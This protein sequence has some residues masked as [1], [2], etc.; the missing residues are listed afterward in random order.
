M[1]SQELREA[2]TNSSFLEFARTLR[3]APPL[4]PKKYFEA[5]ET[6]LHPYS[7][8]VDALFTTPD[9]FK[10]FPYGTVQKEMAVPLVEHYQNLHVE[11]H[12]DFGILHAALGLAGEVFELRNSTSIENSL[13]E[14]GDLF[15]YVIALMQKTDFKIKDLAFYYKPKNQLVR[16][17]AIW[18]TIAEEAIDCTKKLV[19]YE[20]RKK[21]L[22]VS[23][24]LL[25]NSVGRIFAGDYEMNSCHHVEFALSYLRPVIQGNIDKLLKRYPT[26]TFS[27]EES[28]A[29]ADK[30]PS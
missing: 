11:Y 19:I 17:Y 6:F 3:Q 2:Y 16:S 18:E 30:N 20:Q 25:W 14:Q 9:H 12:N 28:H 24:D 13:E 4:T 21:N 10:T 15:F 5:L 23:T 1:N 29:R 8:F 7:R 22:P 26:L 27:T